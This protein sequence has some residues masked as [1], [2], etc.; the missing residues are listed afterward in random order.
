MLSKTDKRAPPI[1]FSALYMLNCIA[2][3]NAQGKDDEARVA[4]RSAAEQ[5]SNAVGPDHP[6]THS[7]LQIAGS[8]SN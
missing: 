4:A 5:L 3:P 6:D 2:S 8:A 7:A 1:H